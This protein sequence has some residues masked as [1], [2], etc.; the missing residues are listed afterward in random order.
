[1][2]LGGT[3]VELRIPE[4]F[5]PLEPLLQDAARS[6]FSMLVSYTIVLQTMKSIAMDSS[7]IVVLLREG[8]TW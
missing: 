2:A 6:T 7:G 8:G 3:R 4:V 5:A 1:M